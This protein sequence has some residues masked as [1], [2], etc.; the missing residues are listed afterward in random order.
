[1]SGDGWDME[2]QAEGLNIKLKSGEYVEGVLVGEPKGGY[3]IWTEENGKSKFFPADPKAP[4]AK[5]RFKI[6]FATKVNGRWVPRILEQGSKVFGDAKR[7]KNAG[8]TLSETIVRIEREGQG[9]NDTKYTLLP[10]P[11]KLSD[12]DLQALKALHLNDL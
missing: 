12:E 7:L 6:N 3:G 4:G 5:F 1:M 10:T 8:Y 2:P 9:K 11:L